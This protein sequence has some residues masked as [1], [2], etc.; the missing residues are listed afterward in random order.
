[1]TP[2]IESPGGCCFRSHLPHMGPDGRKFKIDSDQIM[3]NER[4][5]REFSD[6]SDTPPL[7][8]ETFLHVPF[9]GT[10]LAERLIALGDVRPNFN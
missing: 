6:A 8:F 5:Q 4:V 3:C 9:M 1:M 10:M 2:T 7:S